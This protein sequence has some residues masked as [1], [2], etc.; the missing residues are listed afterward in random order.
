M[1]TRPL[2][3]G[4]EP[5]QSQCSHLLVSIQPI[6]KG[7]GIYRT[8]AG[9]IGSVGWWCQLRDSACWS[10]I[11]LSVLKTGALAPNGRFWR[12][13]WRS[14]FQ[15]ALLAP[16]ISGGAF[17]KFLKNHHFWMIFWIKCNKNCKIRHSK[18]FLKFFSSKNLLFPKINV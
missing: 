4:E 10:M 3:E 5:A 6:R 13:R 16:N 11:M 7:H 12:S 14:K 15:M 18:N 17:S 2:L 1:S 9:R 8:N